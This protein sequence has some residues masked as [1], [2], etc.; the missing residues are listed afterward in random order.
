[1]PA[2]AGPGRPWPR[3]NRLLSGLRTPLPVP[4]VEKVAA[5]AFS[6]LCGTQ[7]SA[8]AVWYVLASLPDVTIMRIVPV[9]VARRIDAALTPI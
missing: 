4:L 5:V 7:C 8:A 6:H 3:R 1:M 9:P 2:T